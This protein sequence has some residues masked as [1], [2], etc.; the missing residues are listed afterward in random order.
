MD[1]VSSGGLSPS[2]RFQKMDQDHGFEVEKPAQQNGVK[3]APQRRRRS[4]LWTVCPFIL[5]KLAC[6]KM[7]VNHNLLTYPVQRHA[8]PVMAVPS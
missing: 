3:A 8:S 7:R 6:C 1:R 4:K 5:G 2:H